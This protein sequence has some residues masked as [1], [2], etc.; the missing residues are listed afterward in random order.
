MAEGFITKIDARNTKF[1]TYYDVYVDNKNLG[2]GKIP[3]KGFEPGDF[4]TF[5]I[6]KNSKG[7]ETIKAGTLSKSSAPQGV[8]APTPPA[9]SSITM[10]KQDVISRQAALNSA[11][12]FVEILGT[13]GA[14][15]EGKTLAAAKKADKLEAILMN[16]VHKFYLIN[17]GTP[18][19]LPEEVEADT[20]SWDEQE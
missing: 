2:G 13:H 8:K 6:E 18:Y 12:N 14:I 7:Y 11:L 1:G 4:V 5:E 15:P 20:T 9:P 16:Y 19:E 17:T 10:D 3:P